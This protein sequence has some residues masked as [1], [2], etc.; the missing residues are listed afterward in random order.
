VTDC[1]F[2][3]IAK[4]DITANVVL[5]DEL[6]VA[7]RD[8]DP[9]APTHI[10]VIPKQHI[11]DLRAAQGDDEALLGHL[12]IMAAE[13]ARIDGLLESGFRVVVNAGPDAGQSVDHLHVHVL[14][15]RRLSWPPG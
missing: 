8:L 7:F 13:A 9:K 2:C 6:A 3:K 15:G 4:G 11:R 1:I 5:Q 12:M 14:G 10:L